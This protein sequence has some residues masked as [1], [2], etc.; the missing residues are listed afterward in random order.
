M[1]SR[2]VIRPDV[3]TSMSIVLADVAHVQY[4]YS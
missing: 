3:V 1:I 2:M 4:R